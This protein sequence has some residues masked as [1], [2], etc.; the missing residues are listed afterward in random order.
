MKRG[1]ETNSVFVYG[2]LKRGAVREVCWPHRPTTIVDAH[3]RGILR[4]LG[5]Y[6]ALIDNPGWVGGECWT[7][8]PHHLAE[9]LTALD[10][11]EIYNQP[12]QENLYRRQIVDCQ[13]Q[14]ASPIPV[15]TYFF[16]HP[17]RIE[18]ALQVP[19]DADGICRWR[20]QPGQQIRDDD[21]HESEWTF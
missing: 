15:Y 11:I 16:A 6:P 2:T 4:D 3:I 21:A 7:F 13:L 9:T 19:P 10:A 20:P 1:V 5:P 17:V 18:N 12:Q 14:N 8:E